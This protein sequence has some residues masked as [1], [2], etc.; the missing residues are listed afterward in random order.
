MAAV[1]VLNLAVLVLGVWFLTSKIIS[2]S[3]RLGE[4]KMALEEISQGQNQIENAKIEE[5]NFEM[6]NFWQSFFSK[7]QPIKFIN[8]LEEF[9]QKTNNDLEINLLAAPEEAKGES[10]LWFRVSLAGSFNN[11]MHFLKYLEN[12]KYYV[13]IQQIQMS[14]VGVSSDNP[15]LRNLGPGDVQSA[16]NLK[17]FVL[18]SL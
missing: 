8:A 13:Q 12:M 16:I 14:R 6:D 18:P 3:S 2:D 15:N 7:D 11:F 10:A 1:I 9:A 17:A 5:I 4:K